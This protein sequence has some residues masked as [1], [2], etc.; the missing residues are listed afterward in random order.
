MPRSRFAG[1]P[2]EA[3]STLFSA[4]LTPAPP[5]HTLAGR[6][7]PRANQLLA[8]MPAA[9]Y[10]RWAPQLEPIDMHLG[11]VL[12]ESGRSMTHVHFPTTGVVS[13][14]YVTESG[15]CSELA[16]VGHEGLVGVSLFLGG[17]STPSR[18]VVLS[19]GQGSLLS[20]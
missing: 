12:Y 3:R 9:V 15:A 14:M 4:R 17:R 11:Q 8:A 7:G 19:E 16:V 5:G 20:G 18:A 1:A 13:L 6:M 10:E 2:S